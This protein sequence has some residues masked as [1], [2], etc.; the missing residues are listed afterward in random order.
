M[1]HLDNMVAVI[2]TIIEDSKENG[3]IDFKFVEKYLKLT[4]D[5]LEFLFSS[6]IGISQHQHS[7]KHQ[8]IIEEAKQVI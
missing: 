1:P 6:M 8:G 2:S 3:L 5:R 4:K 7:R